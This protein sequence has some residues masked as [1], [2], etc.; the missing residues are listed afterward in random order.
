MKIRKD[1]YKQFL[2]T[3]IYKNLKTGQWE[4]DINV[5]NTL[6]GNLISEKFILSDSK[7]RG[8]RFDTISQTED[9][10]Q[11]FKLNCSTNVDEQTF[12]DNIDPVRVIRG[13]P[14]YASCN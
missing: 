6:T 10:E 1:E 13:Y 9:G 7:D 3:I 2:D 8:E 14:V 4:K 11:V 5:I 12:Y